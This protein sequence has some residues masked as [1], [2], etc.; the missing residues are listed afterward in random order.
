MS[1]KKPKR[2]LKVVSK[3][4]VYSSADICPACG[5]YE[6]SGSVCMACKI[7][8]GIMPSSKEIANLLRYSKP[9]Q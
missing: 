4:V 7:K 5:A 2:E 3:N 8:H 6:C 9:K 1:A